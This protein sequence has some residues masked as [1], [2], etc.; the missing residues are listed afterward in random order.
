MEIRNAYTF[1]IGKPEG[2]IP[3]VRNTHSWEDINMEL[4]KITCGSVDWI[5]VA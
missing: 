3:I 5:Q 2:K 4:R 1:L